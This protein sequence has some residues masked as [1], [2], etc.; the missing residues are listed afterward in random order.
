MRYLIVGDVQAK[1]ENL[2]LVKR[3]INDVEA[4]SNDIIWLGDLLDR[5]GHI[6]AELLNLFYEYFSHSKH[7][8]WII[9]G[10]H[11]L[12]SVHSQETALTPL[13]ALENVRIIDEPTYLTK[14]G[15]Y[16]D[17]LMVPYYRNPQKFLEAVND[18]SNEPKPT[19]LICHQGIKEFTLGSGYTEDE[20]VHLSDLQQFQLVVCGHY[21]TPQQKSNVVYVGSPF[22][23]SFGESNENKRLAIFDTSTLNLDYIPTDF[24]Q[25]WTHEFDLTLGLNDNDIVYLQEL[26]ADNYHRVIISGT[27]AQIKEFQKSSLILPHVR[28]LY[29][30]V[31]GTAAVISE[32]LTNNDKWVKWAKDIKKLDDETINLGLELLK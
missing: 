30:P 9:V 1:K 10:N 17:I 22:S 28:Y 11:D 4:Q 21:H 2:H 32:K 3:L 7:N 31:G 14:D 6:E 25:H 24:P 19:T 16:S 26:T 29:R 12:L 23:H 8:H 27:D 5:R 13:K 15:P 20:A 18:P